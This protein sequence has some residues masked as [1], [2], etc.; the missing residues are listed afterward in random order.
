M[1][2]IPLFVFEEHNEAFF[3]WHY[4]VMKKMMPKFGNTLLHVDEHSDMGIPRLNQSINS[5]N[6]SLQDIYKFT[7]SELTIENFIVPAIYQGL[8]N[9]L[10]W[11]RQ[12]TEFPI[13]NSMYVYT[14]DKEGKLLTARNAKDLGTAALF[15]PKYKSAKFKCMTVDDEFA[16]NQSVIL[17]IDLD[18]FSCNHQYHNFRGKLEITEEQYN[19]FN[20]D[21][22]QF[23]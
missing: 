21:K 9:K 12:S 2:A 7:Y 3:I 14:Y 11:I 1:Q 6:G 20:Q 15:N 22:H 5:L 13:P 18:Y 17:D 19:S 16:E 23:F 8:F 4:A 10:Y